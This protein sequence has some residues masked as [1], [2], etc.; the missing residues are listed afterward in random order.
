VRS[1]AS[2]DLRLNLY[3]ANA[4]S[5]LRPSGD[6]DLASTIDIADYIKSKKVAPKDAV[7]ALRRRLTHSN[8]NVVLLALHVCLA[9]ALQRYSEIETN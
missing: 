7:K 6:I 2:I 1:S 9:V 8:P 5:E 3:V 4:T